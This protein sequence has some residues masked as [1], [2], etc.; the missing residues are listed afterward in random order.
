MTQFKTIALKDRY[1]SVLLKSASQLKTDRSYIQRTFLGSPKIQ[2]G[3]YETRNEVREKM[4]K[5]WSKI[6]LNT[7]FIF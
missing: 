5:V 3:E 6:A 1:K 2:N 4:T 7:D